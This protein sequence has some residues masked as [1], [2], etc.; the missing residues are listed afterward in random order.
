MYAHFQAYSQ[1]NLPMGLQT[2][3]AKGSKRSPVH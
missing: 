1:C 3:E 2:K